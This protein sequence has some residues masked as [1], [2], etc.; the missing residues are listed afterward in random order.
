MR[1]PPR[2]GSAV[3]HLLL[4]VLAAMMMLWPAGRLAGQT[5]PASATVQEVD[6]FL[7]VDCLLPGQVRRLG[8]AMTYLSARRPAKLNAE[9]CALRGGE[10]VA[11][12]RADLGTALAVWLPLAE[13]GD[14]Q[15][16]TYAGELYE[17]GIGGTEPDFAKAAMW[18]E[19]AAEQGHAR[20]RINLGFLYEKGLGVPKD[21]AKALD[22][23]REAAGVEVALDD[24]AA[25]GEQQAQL[26]ALR[27]ELEQTRRELEA[28]RETLRQQEGE[29]R[30]EQ[31][32]LQHERDEAR[33]SGSAEEKAHVAALEAR[34]AERESALARQ[35]AEAARLAQTAQR[36][37][38]QL[39]KLQTQR[40]DAAPAP[41]V[42]L[43][44]PSIQLIDPPVVTMRS[45]LTVLLR[46]A[47]AMR[48]VVGKVTAPAG[49]LSFT[50]NDRSQPVDAQG[51][52]KTQVQLSGNATP[53]NLVAVD[54]RGKRAA[55]EFTLVPE[56]LQAAAPAEPAKAPV[57]SLDFGR[58]HALVIGN[59]KYQHLPS[60][61]T[62]EE[63]AR[64][65]SEVLAKKY[66]FQ[67][68][69]LTNATRYEI[70]S[71]LNQMRAKLTEKDNLLIYYAGHG[72]LDRANLR[73][74]WLP[75]DAEPESDAN[76][77]SSVSITD[78]VNAMSVK[79]VLIVA[80]SCYSGAM[81]RSSIAQLEPGLTD[82]AHVK[83]LK[84]LSQARAR[85]VLTSGGVQPV[86][87]GG[88][89][90]HSV[91]A[92]AFLE[93]L[94]DNDGVLEAQRLYREVAA[95]VLVLAERFRVEQKPEYAPLKFAGHESGDFI[96]VARG[97]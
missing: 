72:E 16:Q 20:A 45:P 67:V 44:P 60:L 22:L 35:A 96:F 48:E 83:L 66:G 88:G 46:G 42:A 59:Q 95:R 50:I 41:Q 62:A 55:L 3:F 84:A 23:Y 54:R 29:H 28:A 97:S 63:D 27:R 53:V 56:T 74:H 43:A 33:A 6:R 38:A 92:R 36:Y 32:R 90:K 80:D 69:T 12:D 81:T 10:Y 19:K 77:I 91:F 87:D 40:S 70:L 37:Q 15:A 14:A 64:A 57:P 79:H 75:V 94:Q 93:V 31:Q 9:E 68:T 26:E 13:Q 4:V 2:L 76:W 73:G 78:I 89:G 49:L 17:R 47:P 11:Y 18:Y 8:M 51:L 30:S 34:L 7:I 24:T 82:Q 25:S 86:M 61:D 21:P 1:T 85:T 58:Y 39:A 5:A 65:V 71:A 52:F